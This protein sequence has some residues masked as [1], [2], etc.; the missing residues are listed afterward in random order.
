MGQLKEKLSEANISIQ[1]TIEI[2]EKLTENISQK[3]IQIE[4]HAKEIEGY[5]VIT[6]ERNELLI[7]LKEKEIAEETMC[8]QLKEI[9]LKL[10]EQSVA[11]VTLLERLESV[12]VENDQKLLSFS[13]EVSKLKEALNLKKTDHEELLVK[14]EVIRKELEKLKCVEIRLEEISQD[15]IKLTELKLDLDAKIESLET[16]LMSERE[17]CNTLKSTTEELTHNFNEKNKK[18]QFEKLTE[19][20]QL[21]QNE[22]AIQVEKLQFEKN[23]LETKITE[24]TN[25]SNS[26]TNDLK[27]KLEERIQANQNYQVEISNLEKENEQLKYEQEQLMND[28]NSAEID[29]KSL[30]SK[31]SEYLE[32][33]NILE[34]KRDEHEAEMRAHK[35]EMEKLI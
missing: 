34:M 21:Q 22:I 28:R 29:M 19:T 6:E 15:N 33:I 5:R 12:N 26:S 10:E 13:S 11:K 27:R 7:I 1:K 35:K 3:N 25:S 31:I 16:A 20:F 9:K 17:N 32:Q 30:S 2:N 14:H 8:N 4:D 24:L 23:A 18:V